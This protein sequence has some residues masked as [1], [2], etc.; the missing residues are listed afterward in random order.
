MTAVYK[1]TIGARW[2]VNCKRE[3]FYILRNC[4]S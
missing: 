1:S 4:V 2:V 3:C